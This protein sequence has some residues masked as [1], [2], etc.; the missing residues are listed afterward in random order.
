MDVTNLQSVAATSNAND[1]GCSEESGFSQTAS[2]NNQ[3][4]GLTPDASGNTTSDGTFTYTWDAESQLKAA[5]GVTYVYDGEGRRMAKS[6]SKLYWYGAGDEIL[7]ETNSSGVTT[8]EYIFF[9]GK[10]IAM[11]PA[12]SAPIY[13]V[14]DLLGTSRVITSNTGAVCYDADFYPYGGER[15]V[16][17]SC[18]QNAYKFEGQERDT[19]TGNDAFDARYY[20]SRF[21]R[22]LSADWSAV[23]VAVPYATLANPQTLNLYAIVDDDPETSAD[24]D[25]HCFWDACVLEGTAVYYAAAAVFTAA[26][27]IKAV[28]SSPALQSAVQNAASDVSNTVSN[29]I[30]PS[31]SQSDS[32]ST[33]PPATPGTQADAQ[34]TGALPANPDDLTEQGYNDVSHPDAAAAGHQTFE[35]PR[36]GDRVRFDKAK[37]GAPG[38]AGKDHYHRHNPDSTSNKDKYLDANGNPVPKGSDE[39][40]LQPQQPSPPPS[41][42]EPKGPQQP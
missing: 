29:L 42:A 2:A 14:E 38:H 9:A 39:S 41:P 16:T 24:L 10:R 26:V 15:A 30:H 23:P 4:S 13:Y 7:A 31:P 6:G 18:T 20:S 21:G 34:K 32:A 37:P 19:E 12:G 3:L 36:T 22:W 25:G 40:H 5:A 11:I 28:A 35:N 1:T 27:A 33:S 17:N 8:A